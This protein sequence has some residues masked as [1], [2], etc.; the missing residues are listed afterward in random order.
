MLDYTCIKFPSWF[1]CVPQ[2]V[3]IPMPDHNHQK[4]VQPE[5]VH[6]QQGN[7][8]VVRDRNE[9]TNSE[10]FYHHHSKPTVIIEH[11]VIL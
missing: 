7:T 2:L 11:I 6:L 3:T 8:L 4:I 1:L 5:S 10:Q 9:K